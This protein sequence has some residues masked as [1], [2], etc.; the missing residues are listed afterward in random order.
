MTKILLRKK[1][2]YVSV[3]FVYQKT[4]INAYGF[5]NNIKKLKYTMKHN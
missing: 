3:K 1:M 5:K 2:S 4:N